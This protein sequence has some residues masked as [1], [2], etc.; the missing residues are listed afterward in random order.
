MTDAQSQGTK[1]ASTV[2]RDGKTK[3]IS[4]LFNKSLK[5]CENPR[6]P[7]KWQA[8][9]HAGTMYIYIKIA[10]APVP[11]SSLYRIL[12]IAALQM[13]YGYC[14]KSLIALAVL[15]RSEWQRVVTMRN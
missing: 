1:V 3:R 10:G 4:R 5:L 2:A 14:D 8:L 11:L 6:S 15:S 7:D 12:Q 9:C 13:R